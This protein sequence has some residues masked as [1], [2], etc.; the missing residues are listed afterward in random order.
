MAFN[1][2]LFT[3]LTNTRYI[4]V[5]I[6]C[7]MFP[8]LGQRDRECGRRFSCILKLA[9]LFAAPRVATL[10]VSVAVFGVLYRISPKSVSDCGGYPY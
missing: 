2:P 10:S 3:K 1:F 6:S 5:D 9:V 7:R 4:F 8:Q